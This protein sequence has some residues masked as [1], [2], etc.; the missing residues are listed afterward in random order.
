MFYRENVVD[1]IEDQDI[2]EE[3]IDGLPVGATLDLSLIH[4]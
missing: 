1:S 4:I 3:Y 2:T